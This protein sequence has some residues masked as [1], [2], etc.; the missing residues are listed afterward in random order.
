MNVESRAIEKRESSSSAEEKSAKPVIRR[1]EMD[2]VDRMRADVLAED[3]EKLKKLMDDMT[4]EW[5]AI[6]S[7]DGDSPQVDNQIWYESF[8]PVSV[9]RMLLRLLVILSVRI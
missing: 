7:N 3:N 6:V 4:K 1:G 9:H 8:S 2:D 5:S